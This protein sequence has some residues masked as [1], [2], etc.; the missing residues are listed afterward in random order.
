MAP[1]WLLLLTCLQKRSISWSTIRALTVLETCTTRGN[2]SA[3]EYLTLRGFAH[4]RQTAATQQQ[5]AIKH[6]SRASK[7]RFL[8]P[9]EY[10][11][12][13][14]QPQ[15]SITPE[16]EV[17]L[18]VQGLTRGVFR[19]QEGGTRCIPGTWVTN[20]C[21]TLLDWLQ[22]RVISHEAWDE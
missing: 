4:K 16:C 1:L 20:S 9:V 11:C 14:T 5:Q 15:P 12:V 8:L 10:I 18:A 2:S 6:E 7:K 22:K 13:V 21:L 17:S 19:C 3:T